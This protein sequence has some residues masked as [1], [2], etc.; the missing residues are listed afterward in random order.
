MRRQERLAADARN[1]LTTAQWQEIVAAHGGRCAYCGKKPKKRR[2]TM[3]H[4]TPLSRD[5]SNTAANVV[6]ACKS[7]NSKKWIHG[8]LCPV[9]PVLL[10]LAPAKAGIS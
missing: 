8:P 1:D 5:G 7:C 2:L 6:P 4:I 9:Q 10:T 3:D